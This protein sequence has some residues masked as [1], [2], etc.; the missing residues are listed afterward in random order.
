MGADTAVDLGDMDL[1]SSIG[2]FGWLIPAFFLGV[3]GLL[4]IVVV[5][6]QVLGGG[7]FVPI[8]SRV[9][10]GRRR[11]DDREPAA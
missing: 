1:M 7:A 3:P 6:A 11:S 5:S 4:L 9:L 10:G 8:T 2:M